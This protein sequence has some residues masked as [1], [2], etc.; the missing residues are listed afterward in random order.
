MIGLLMNVFSTLKKETTTIE[1]DIFKIRLEIQRKGKKDNTSGSRNI[2][3]K[4]GVDGKREQ[5]VKNIYWRTSLRDLG[6]VV[7]LNG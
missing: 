6:L 7:V 5:H 2:F 4:H 3:Y 1:D